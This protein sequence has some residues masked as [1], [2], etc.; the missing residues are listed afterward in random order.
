MG[1]LPH[2]F[3]TPASAIP[4]LGNLTGV[5]LLF[6][7]NFCK[8]IFMHLFLLSQETMLLTIYEYNQRSKP[9]DPNIAHVGFGS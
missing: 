4:C 7:V 8:T 6:H 9:T 1:G 2:S 3:Q 5:I